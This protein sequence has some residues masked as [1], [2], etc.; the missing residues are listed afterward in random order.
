MA[1]SKV[2]RLSPAYAGLKKYVVFFLN[3]YYK[4]NIKNID[5]IQSD[6]YIILV[7]NHQNS[8]IDALV[9]L[10][11]GDFQPYFMARSDIF[12]NKTVASVLQFLRLMPVYRMRDGY[13]QL[14]QN[15]QSFLK[16]YEILKEK[17]PVAIFPEGNH[18]DKY[19]LRPFKKGVTRIGF[20]FRQ[21]DKTHNLKIVP[22]GLNYENHH[23][24]GSNLFVSVGEPINIA[25]FDDLY[26]E[27][28][29]KA[30]A[31][32]ISTL[33]KELRKNMIS[34]E[35]QER[36]DVISNILILYGASAQQ[37]KELPFQIFQAQKAIA[38][39]LEEKPDSQFEEISLV[40]RQVESLLKDENLSF[41]DLKYK[42]N[43]SSGK[44][45]IMQMT[46]ALLYPFYL[47][48]LLLNIIPAGL[49]AFITGK[50][51]DPQFKSSVDFTGSIFIYPVIYL[52]QILIFGLISV[53]L[54][55]TWL[56]MVSLPLSLGIIYLKK[57]NDRK[58]KI[59]R[60]LKKIS[61]SLA[62]LVSKLESVT[63][64]GLK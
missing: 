61:K 5:R 27:N 13:D 11:L 59:G 53:N 21:L 55:W 22:V 4:I 62:I 58:L 29:V 15:D 49:M 35:N 52:L 51:K 60:S 44:L 47:A 9:L 39:Q 42:K 43:T 41:Q 3:R 32:L 26:D 10:S 54:I 20:G 6:D 18:D 30:T 48:S 12:A 2:K 45:N 7:A 56:Y 38:T 33:S 19:R 40:V 28:P 63:G 23:E 25:D 17:I 34:I 14:T 37:R 50:I 16:A 24:P 46:R 8:L 64:F 36:Y 1:S 31:Q 57:Q